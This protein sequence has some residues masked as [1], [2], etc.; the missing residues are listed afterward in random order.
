VSNY[1]TGLAQLNPQIKRHNGGTTTLTLD[2]NGTTN[3]TLLFVNGVAQTPG[4]DFNVSGTTLTTTST[5]PA[6]TNICT[7]IQYFNTGIVNTVADNAITNAKMADDAIGIAELSATGTASSSTFLRGDNSWGSAGSNVL[8][9]LHMVCDGS[10]TTVSSGTYTSTNVTAAQNATTTYADLTGSSINYTPPSGAKT[11]LY[12][13]SCGTGYL[14]AQA[15]TH[16]NL[17]LD[18]T[19]VTN[20]RNSDGHSAGLNGQMIHFRWPFK[21]GDGAVAASGKVA[22][23]SSAKIIKLQIRAGYASYEA[24]FHESTYWDGG[25]TSHIH[26]PTLSVTSLS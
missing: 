5:L 14:D 9:A 13:F 8:E 21:I 23:W 11:V 20:A 25:T 4:I 12:E 18:G 17:Y 6:G 26:K 24:K 1:L 19:E 7:T 22:S 15:I 2:E 16:F 10:S 3:A